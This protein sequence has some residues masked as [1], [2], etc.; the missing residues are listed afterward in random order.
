MYPHHAA[1]FADFNPKFNS[2]PL[3]TPSG[4]IGKGEE[5]RRIR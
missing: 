2:L 5:H 4:V 3:G 1:V